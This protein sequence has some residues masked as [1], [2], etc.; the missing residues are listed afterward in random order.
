VVELKK[1]SYFN[2]G[3]C[4]FLDGDITGL[5]IKDSEIR[6]FRW[7]DDEGEPKPRVLVSAKLTDVFEK[8]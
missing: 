5:E 8:C 3:C 6:L 2:T 4:A 1:P 7:P